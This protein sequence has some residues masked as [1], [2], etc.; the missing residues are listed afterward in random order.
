MTLYCSWMRRYREFLQP[1]YGP[2]KCFLKHLPR[3]HPTGR[4]IHHGIRQNGEETVLDDAEKQFPEIEARGLDGRTYRVPE[5]LEGERNIP[6]V[7]FIAISS[8]R[9]TGGC[10]RCS[11]SSP[12]MAEQ[13]GRGCS[14]RRFNSSTGTESVGLGG[15]CCHPRPATARTGSTTPARPSASSRG[16]YLRRLHQARYRVGGHPGVLFFTGPVVNWLVARSGLALPSCGA[17][18]RG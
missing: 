1:A 12:S 5:E 7:A 2:P 6:L 14:S 13:S 18:R 9:S 4:W 16:S 8:S 15:Q 3:L 11:S 17:D 10:R